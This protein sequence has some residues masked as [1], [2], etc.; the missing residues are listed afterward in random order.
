[1]MIISDYTSENINKNRMMII[2]DGT[3]LQFY[4][5]INTIK[6]N[7]H[8]SDCTSENSKIHNDDYLQSYF[9]KQ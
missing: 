5:S 8:H 4:F 1:M 7:D 3:Y 9:K 6:H 2:S